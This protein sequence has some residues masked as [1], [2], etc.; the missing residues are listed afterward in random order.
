M[1]PAD[2]NM[3]KKSPQFFSIH[4]KIQFICSKQLEHLYSMNIAALIG[5]AFE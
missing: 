3:Y 2:N 4:Q 5:S 1:L